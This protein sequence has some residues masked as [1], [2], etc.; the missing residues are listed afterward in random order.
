MAESKAKPL[1][2]STTIRNPE[3]I[4]NFLRCILP[5]EGQ[6]LTSDVIHEVIKNVIREKEYTPMYV[7]R[8]PDLKAI[9]MNP[10]SKYSDAQLEVIIERSPQKH[11]EAGFA[12]GWDSRFDTWYKMI[13]EFGF[14][15]YSMND[16]IVI[17]P[18]GHM[19]VDAYLEEPIN[20]KK[21]QLVFL[22]ALM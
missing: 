15:K 3:R 12:Y 18:T 5:Y 22:N 19:L 16:F 20:E 6:I 17:T 7:T 13:K 1:S 9:L 8:T 21:I 11:K 2:F 4:P 14:I 10:D